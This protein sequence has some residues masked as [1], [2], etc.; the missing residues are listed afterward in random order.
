MCFWLVVTLKYACTCVQPTVAFV[1]AVVAQLTGRR[2]PQPQA[3]SVSTPYCLYQHDHK[4]SVVCVVRTQA[5]E[6]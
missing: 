4:R 1:M 3:G 5:W 6:P 2:Q